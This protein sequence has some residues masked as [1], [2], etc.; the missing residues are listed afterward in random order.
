MISQKDAIDIIA[1]MPRTD[2]LLCHDGPYERYLGQMKTIYI[3]NIVNNPPL[4]L[5]P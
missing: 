2:I 4:R 5:T 1:D 3:P